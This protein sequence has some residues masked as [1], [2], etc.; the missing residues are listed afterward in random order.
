MALTIPVNR[1]RRLYFL[2]RDKKVTYLYAIFS[3]CCHNMLSSWDPPMSALYWQRVLWHKLQ[4]SNRWRMMY[5]AYLELFVLQTEQDRNGR[6]AWEKHF[7]L[8]LCALL[9]I[10][11]PQTFQMAPLMKKERNEELVW[12]R[13]LEAWMKDCFPLE[14]PINSIYDTPALFN[15]Q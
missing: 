5:E 1:M 6:R 8:L 9:Q 11:R 4:T 15:S 10:E 7:N 12:S 2:Y 14:E 13:L 3:V